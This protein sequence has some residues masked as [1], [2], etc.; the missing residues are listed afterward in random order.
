[1]ALDGMQQR[2]RWGAVAIVL[3]GLLAGAWL[4]PPPSTSRLVGT[5]APWRLPQFP[6]KDLR[7]ADRD[8]IQIGR[9]MPF[10]RQ[11]S[12]TDASAA[13]GNTAARAT[14]LLAIIMAP[15]LQALIIQDGQTRVRRYS[16]GDKLD[17]GAVLTR[18]E[19]TQIELSAGA[20]H[21]KVYLFGRHAA[22]VIPTPL[23]DGASSASAK[24]TAAMPVESH[25]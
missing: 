2:L 15:Q 14:R 6:D 18:I 3:I 10:G 1:M 13:A 5:L 4:L 20:C 8:L 21:L 9:R 12:A 7:Y 16:V 11:S 24:A 25:R 22:N 23:C 17:N 19:P